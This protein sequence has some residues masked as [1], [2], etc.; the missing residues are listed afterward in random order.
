MRLALRGGLALALCLG[1]AVL[2]GRAQNPA[3]AADDLTTVGSQDPGYRAWAGKSQ[4]FRVAQQKQMQM[5]K[6]E[7]EKAAKAAKDNP[8]AN[9]TP[10]DIAEER[11][12]AEMAYIRRLEV[13]DKLTAIGWETNDFA[14]LE[15]VAKLSDRALEIYQKKT[16]LSTLPVKPKSEQ[17]QPNLKQSP[18]PSAETGMI[19]PTPPP[20]NKNSVARPEGNP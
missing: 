15:Q 17:P 10:K 19:L 14:L 13:C 16:G 4:A 9:R 7:A 3:P 11:K 18:T 1:L 2:Q 8:K 6:E 20:T 5:E 12:Q